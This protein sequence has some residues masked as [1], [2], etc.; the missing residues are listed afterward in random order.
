M[1]PHSH[2]YLGKKLSKLV[3]EEYKQYFILGNVTPDIAL[4]HKIKR[5]EY[6]NLREWFLNYIENTMSM[7]LGG[8]RMA[9][10]RLGVISH[11]LADFF[12]YAH[13]N[14]T[15]G[16]RKY[17]TH[18]YYEKALHQA[19]FQYKF[20]WDQTKKISIYKLDKNLANYH[21]K[22]EEEKG[23]P[24]KDLSYINFMTAGV[25]HAASEYFWRSSYQSNYVPG[26]RLLLPEPN[27]FS[28]EERDDG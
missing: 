19:L 25:V 5:H 12:C 15:I 11:Y 7:T 1:L 27:Y 2:L 13:N 23:E 21:A 20:D 9:Y 17:I 14:G 24:V 16:N 6:Y 4:E 8:K 28:F 10:Y 18:Y 26:K 3:E 22:Y